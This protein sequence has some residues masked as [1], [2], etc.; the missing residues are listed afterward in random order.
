MADDKLATNCALSDNDQRCKFLDSA[1]SKNDGAEEASRR[2]IVVKGLQNDLISWR[3][4]PA[5]GAAATV[6]GSD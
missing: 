5:A 1:S 6:V 4:W 3:I 2:P